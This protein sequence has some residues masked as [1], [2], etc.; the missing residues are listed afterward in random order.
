MSAPSKTLL[1]RY[2]AFIERR[3][4]SDI[5]LYHLVL[6]VVIGS[7]ITALISYNNTFI[8]T[9]PTA[10][11]TLVEGIV[12]TPRFVNPVLAITRADHD[13]AALVYSGLLKIDQHGNLVNDIAESID[14]SE[15]GR[16]YHITL[17]SNVRFHDGSLLTAR[18][19]AFTIALI[20]NPDLK[21]PLRGNWENVIVEELGETE[22]NITLE[23][24][25]APFI[26]NF[27]L[28]ILPRAIWDELPIEQ[29]P[30]SQ[31]NTEPIG[32]GPY[33]IT[34]VLRNKAGLINAYKLEAFTAASNQPNID[35]IVFNFYQN[36]EAL[37]EALTEG[38]IAATPSLSTDQIQTLDADTY[39]VI[40]T[41]IPRTFSLYFNQNK[42]PALRDLAARQALS[43]AID[44]NALVDRV[45]GGYG[46]PTDTPIPPG[47][48][49]LE[50]ASTTLE[51]GVATRPDSLLVAGGWQKNTDGIWEKDINGEVTPLRVTISTANTP[52]FEQTATVIAEQWRAIG[53]E[54][55][56]DQYEQTD[57]VQG[58][59]RPRDFQALL[60]GADLGRSVDLYPFWHSSQ[61]DDPGLNIAQ[62]TNITAD[63][64]L[65]DIRRTTDDTERTRAIQAVLTE[66]Q[67]DQP[68]TFLFA[69][70]FT[71]VIDTAVEIVPFAKLG[72]PSERFA[73][74]ADW[75]ITA[76]RLW[77]IFSN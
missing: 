44:K 30:F 33:V 39:A 23:E 8:A 62:Y 13:I 65:E 61:K 17:R 70:N 66:I 60:F 6:A 32:S 5:V 29:L 71:Y 47:F 12:G 57:L 15:D 51:A 73:N 1:D 3:K 24:P 37:L 7:A 75:H 22:L 35:T 20:Q 67:S 2:F 36:E 28:G 42:S 25:Y 16:T 46:V 43:A 18:D 54:V 55:Q 10:G 72:K 21:S 14:L 52:L 50:S 49:T 41:P 45:L 34:D 68:A 74:V 69:P 53:I 76:S 9:V 64:L 58:I 27:T 11:G 40:E 56:V 31:H 19:V 63:G 59:I 48:I 4:L 26:E 77:P 38:E